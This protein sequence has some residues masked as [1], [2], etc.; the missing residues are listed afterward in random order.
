MSVISVNGLGSR[1]GS[2]NNG[3]GC[4]TAAAQRLARRLPP[5][6]ASAPMAASVSSSS[7]PSSARRARSWTDANGRASR[8]RSIARAARSRRPF[9]YRNPSR[10]TRAP[11]A[12]S[13]THNHGERVTSIGRIRSPWRCASFTMVAG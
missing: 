6:G 8:A 11:S 12:R 2:A 1:G 10:T 13:S 4:G 9:T 7:R 3:P 5:S